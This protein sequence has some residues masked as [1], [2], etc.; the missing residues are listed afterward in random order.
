M[1]KLKTFLTLAILSLGF[2]GLTLQKEKERLKTEAVVFTDEYIRI[3]VVRLNWWHD[4]D[5]FQPLVIADDAGFQV[6]AKEIAPED[7]VSAAGHGEGPYKNEYLAAGFLF[8]DVKYTEIY[9]KYVKLG[10]RSAS[11]KI[12]SYWDQTSAQVFGDSHMHTVWRMYTSYGNSFYA[13]DD[14]DNGEGTHVNNNFVAHMLYGYL[15]CSN[16]DINGYMAYGTLNARFD[17]DKR[18][19]VDDVTVYDF[20]DKDHYGSGRYGDKGDESGGNLEVKLGEK[21]TAMKLA[22]EKTN[23][24]QS[25]LIINTPSMNTPIIISTLGLTTIT[26]YYFLTRKKKVM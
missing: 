17:L 16:S 10:R 23:N 18:T 21:I 26:G 12:G 9:G 25:Q 11:G 19:Q 13:L 22:Y 5:A 8:Y 20:A 1:Q 2:T 6:N 15:T 14:N 24:K 4:N 3:P 7:W